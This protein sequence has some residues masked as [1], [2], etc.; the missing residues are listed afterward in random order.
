[1]PL[2]DVENVTT[3]PQVQL[4]G[5]R[6]GRLAAGGME[7]VDGSEV[8][9]ADRRSAGLERGKDLLLKAVPPVVAGD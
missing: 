8:V 3:G 4:R 6:G 5:E 7:L 2:P 9:D 1:M